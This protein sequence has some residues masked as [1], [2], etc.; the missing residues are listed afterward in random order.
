MVAATPGGTV[1]IQP[2]GIGA[3]LRGGPRVEDPDW[4]AFRVV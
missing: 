3:F 2:G 4:A 1:P